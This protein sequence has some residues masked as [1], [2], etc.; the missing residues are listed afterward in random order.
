MVLE[1]EQILRPQF[2]FTV[3]NLTFKELEGYEG[4]VS[5]ILKSDAGFSVHTG[6]AIFSGDFTSFTRVLDRDKFRSQNF[7][8]TIQN[9]LLNSTHVSFSLLY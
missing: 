1:T 8:T 9:E 3:P 5:D 7:R 4:G 2:C 6:M